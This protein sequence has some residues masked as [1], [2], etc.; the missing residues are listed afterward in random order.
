MHGFK[1]HLAHIKN[2]EA[3][4]SGTREFTILTDLTRIRYGHKEPTVGP[5]GQ[6]RW[7]Y[8]Y[9]GVSY[10]TDETSRH[11]ITS[12]KSEDN[13]SAFG[14]TNYGGLVG[15]SVHVVLVVDHSGSMRKSDVPG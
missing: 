13:R 3:V 9:N 8:T 6:P 12:W 1:C 11:E 4:L 10:V 5:E 2:C 14:P 7:K 15:C